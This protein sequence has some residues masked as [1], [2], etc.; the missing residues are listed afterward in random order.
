MDKLK[1]GQFL[2]TKYLLK[3]KLQLINLMSQIY[4]QLMIVSWLAVAQMD[5]LLFGID[6][7]L[8][9]YI[10]YIFNQKNIIKLIKKNYKHMIFI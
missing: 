7:F 1:Y 5:K 10:K 2:T 8:H 3:K 4:V 6:Y 9:I